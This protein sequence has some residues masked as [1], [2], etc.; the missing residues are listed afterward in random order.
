[1]DG[2]GG[3]RTRTADFY[4]ANAIRRVR[5]VPSD[6]VCAG[7]RGCGVRAVLPRVAHQREF[8]GQSD[9][10]NPRPWWARWRT[11]VDQFGSCGAFADRVDRIVTAADMPTARARP[12]TPTPSPTGLSAPTRSG[13][14]ASPNSR[15]TSPA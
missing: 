3:E 14:P 8:D 9:G 11:R 13:P 4:V 10:Q 5:R 1:M 7:Q 6:D 12:P 2:G 15:P